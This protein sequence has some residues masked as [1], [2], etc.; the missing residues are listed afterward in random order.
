MHE[1][2]WKCQVTCTWI[3]LHCLH[4]S[5]VTFGNTAKRVCPATSSETCEHLRIIDPEPVGHP[6]SGKTHRQNHEPLFS[7]TPVVLFRIGW[8]CWAYL[9]RTDCPI[10]VVVI[11]HLSYN[12][13]LL[14]SPSFAM[15]LTGCILSWFAASS[16][17]PLDNWGK[18]H[19][20]IVV[21]CLVIQGDDPRVCFMTNFWPIKT[22]WSADQHLQQ[23][24]LATASHRADD[25]GHSPSKLRTLRYKRSLLNANGTWGS[26]WGQC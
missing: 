21:R 3:D 7:G 6:L 19:L 11:N 12:E 9:L 18:K 20:R 14:Y 13:W 8:V 24:D 4:L 1:S 10:L 26:N 16:C 5:V 2:K 23:Q 17:N 25:L 22:L 15:I